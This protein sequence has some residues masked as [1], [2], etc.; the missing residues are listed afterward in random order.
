MLH[1]MIKKLVIEEILPRKNEF[2]RPLVSNID[3][4]FLVTSLINPDFSIGLL[5]RFITPYGIT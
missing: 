5:D 3:Q 4:A 1:L 2:A